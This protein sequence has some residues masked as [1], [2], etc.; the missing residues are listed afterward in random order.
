MKL[1]PRRSILCL[2]LLA[3]LGSPS[4]RT[5]AQS[6]PLDLWSSNTQLI[7][8]DKSTLN[9]SITARIGYFEVYFDSN[10][11]ATWADAVAPYAIHTGGKI[12]IHGYLASPLFGGPYP[13]I[14]IGHGHHG[15]GDPNEA[16]LL[17]ALGYV[18]LS[19]DGPGQ[20]LS[21]GPPDTE[22]GW[23]SVERIMNV[24][25]PYVSYQYHYAYAGMRALTLFEGLSGLFLNPFRIDRTRFGVIGASMGGQFTYYING[26]DDRVKGAVAIAAAGDWGKIIDY[27]GSWL[28]HGA[29]YYTR[30]SLPDG[31]DTQRNMIASTC[32][33][34]WLTF[35]RYFDPAN[36]AATQHGPL[37]TI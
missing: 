16:M 26:V 9:Y 13:A 8:R 32:D 17:A 28:Y 15:H 37:L 4:S 18:V 1:A 34:T 19:I 12:R 2:L 6:A 3:L 7:I 33:P 22:Q 25:A 29:Y 31:P 24:P 14:V 11:N 36:Y 10:N 21:T 23:I 5:F 27:P 20:G 35:S 30:N